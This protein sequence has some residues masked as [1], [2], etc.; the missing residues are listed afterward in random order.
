MARPRALNH[1][2]AHP[3]HFLE[4]IN[5]R[6]SEKIHAALEGEQRYSISL[7]PPSRKGTRF[8]APSF[9]SLVAFEGV[10][11]ICGQTVFSTAKSLSL[12]LSSPFE[13]GSLG[14]LSLSSPPKER[15]FFHRFIFFCRIIAGFIAFNGQR[16]TLPLLF[17]PHS[18]TPSPL[19]PR[20]LFV[21]SVCGRNEMN[22]SRRLI[23]GE[24]GGGGGMI[25]VSLET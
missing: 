13:D 7:P 15:R 12:S 8:L 2:T 4:I 20:S 11:A 25:G 5:Q 9:C 22:S 1:T 24:R 10:E 18:S 3:L 6:A 17:P 19:S 21:H 14:G 23:G 16:I